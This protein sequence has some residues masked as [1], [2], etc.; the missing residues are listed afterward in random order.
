MN[1]KSDKDLFLPEVTFN[2]TYER[3]G[4]KPGSKFEF[5]VKAGPALKPALYN[6]CRTV[7]KT[8]KLPICSVLYNPYMPVLLLIVRLP[9]PF[10]QLLNLNVM[11]K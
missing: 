11:N 9:H 8:E 1:D 10:D 5:I 2:S 4:K 7:W 3:L 6:L